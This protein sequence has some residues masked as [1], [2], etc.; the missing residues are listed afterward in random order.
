MNS[1]QHLVFVA[2]LAFVSG[3]SHDEPVEA[4]G[5]SVYGLTESRTVAACSEQVIDAVGPSGI[6]NA[7]WTWNVAAPS[8]AS[9]SSVPHDDELQFVARTPGEYLI[10]V[11]ACTSAQDTSEECN[12]TEF[13]MTV[14]VGP[15]ANG[16][17]VCDACETTDCVPAC[18]GRTCGLD[19]VCQKSC[20]TCT[21]SQS[22]ND[23][24][25]QCEAACVPACD[26]RSCGID[27]IC[28]K[29]CG[30]CGVGQTC[31]ESA[32]QCN[33]AC[34][35]ACD[36]RTCGLDPVCHTSCGTCGDGSTCNATGQCEANASA[37]RVVTIVMALTDRRLAF[38]DPRF[39]QRAK[40]IEQSV[41]W[42]SPTSAPKVLVVLDDVVS[43]WGREAQQIRSTLMRR[44]FST[45]LIGEPANGLTAKQVADYDV[46]WF[47][48]PALPVDDTLTI[49]TLTAF[50]HAG[51]GLVLQG[52]DIT[53]PKQLEALTRLSHVGNG[54]SYCGQHFDDD[55]GASYQVTIERSKHAVT[56]GLRGNTYYYGDDLD[57]SAFVPTVG[58][59]VLAWAQVSGCHRKFGAARQCQKQP[60]IVAYDLNP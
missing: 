49:S 54:K 20:G 8:E 28:G 43:D 25:G 9:F 13:A 59:T 22:C 12:T 14:V 42:V 23:D 31:D 41:R 26:G 18:D 55:R 30:T 44:G 1:T 29:S 10:S 32:G 39:S 40:L 46:V 47:S 60:V 51:G 17:Q 37:G 3:C 34:V 5:L 33:A 2:T 19:P 38:T 6:T 21:G 45:T 52:D 27:P 48:N 56:S 50:V 15:D 24:S 35:P 16:N 53:Q 4:P 57:N 58:A 36:G 7:T 11:T